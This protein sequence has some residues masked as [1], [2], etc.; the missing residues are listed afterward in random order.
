MRHDIVN[1]KRQRFLT[2]L[3][4]GSSKISCLIVK[5]AAAPDWLEGKGDSIHFEV[6]GVGHQRA[7]GVKS[8]MIAHL[9]SAEHAI[10]APDSRLFCLGPRVAHLHAAL[11]HA[12]A[13]PPRLRDLANGLRQA[14]GDDVIVSVT[15]G[16]LKSESF[17]ASVAIANGAVRDDDILRILAGGR[18]YAGRDKRSV[19]P[20]LP[21]GYRLDATIGIRDPLAK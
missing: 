18:Q 14:T 5:P 8:G 9:D 11:V 4:V 1:R 2:A 10:R 21:I 6:L 16:R 13:V 19:L 3:D 12:F 17:S 20:A 15:A 7:E